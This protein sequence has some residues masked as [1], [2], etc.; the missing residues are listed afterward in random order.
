MRETARKLGI[1]R[2]TVAR[3]KKFLALRAESWLKDFLKTKHVRRMQFDDMETFEHSKLKPL[4]V[5]L[6]VEKKTRLILGFDVAVMPAKGKLVKR[7][8]AKYG[9]RPD[10][11]KKVRRAVFDTLKPFIDER[12]EIET[13]K[14]PHYEPDIKDFFPQAK[15][16]KYKGRRGCVVGQGEL[17]AGGHDPIFSLNHTAAMFRGNINRLFRRTWCT[18][19]K[20]SGLREHILIY[21]QS[22]NQRILAKLAKA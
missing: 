14:N 1:H 16:K 17:K 15:H 4:S 6:A 21:A 5:P 12:A 20:I 2:T 8:L 18:T 22:H 10:E 3:K 11:R 7:S 9:P 19:K 13:D